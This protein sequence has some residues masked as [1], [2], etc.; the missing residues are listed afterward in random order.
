MSKKKKTADVGT[1]VCDCGRDIG[2]ARV[3]FGNDLLSE[4]LKYGAELLEDNDRLD[5]N[6]RT[7]ADAHRN[8]WQTE[9]QVE[10]WKARRRRFFGAWHLTVK[11][12]LTPWSWRWKPSLFRSSGV[13]EIRWLMFTVEAIEG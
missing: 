1:L 8:C 5:A 7:I 2:T 4:S 6:Y 13:W 3:T 10:Y 12:D 9:K 11:V